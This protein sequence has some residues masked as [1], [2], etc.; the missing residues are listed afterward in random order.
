MSEVEPEAVV[1]GQLSLHVQ[2]EPD[3]DAGV[4]C[5][6]RVQKYNLTIHLIHYQGSNRDASK[7]RVFYIT[8][9]ARDPVIQ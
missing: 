8:E 4:A 2:V 3:N 1:G 6:C 9:A 7:K 5:N